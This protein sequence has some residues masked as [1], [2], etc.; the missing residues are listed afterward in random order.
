M[1]HNHNHSNPNSTT[2]RL[3]ATMLLNFLITAAEI[4]GGILSGSL[5]LISDALHNFS[6]GFQ[7]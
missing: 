3:I 4:I 5:A 2:G 7:L 6:D 1:G